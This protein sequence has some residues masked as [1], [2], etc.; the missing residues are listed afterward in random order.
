MAWDEVGDVLNDR[1]LL[2]HFG[3]GDTAV[4]ETEKRGTDIDLILVRRTI[5]PCPSP[6]GDGP[7]SGLDSIILVEW[8]KRQALRIGSAMR[9]DIT[10]S[11]LFSLASLI[12][13][14]WRRPKSI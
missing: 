1:N 6:G 4:G 13:S 7:D 8:R 14:G 12:K 10:G 5:H 9:L 3:V 11:K 2:P